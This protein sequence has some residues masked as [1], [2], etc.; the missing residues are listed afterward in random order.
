MGGGNLGA[1]AGNKRSSG[2]AA[3][4]NGTG[5]KQTYRVTVRAF[6]N[7]GNRSAAF[8]LGTFTVAR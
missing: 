8:S 3:V 5:K 4:A 7:S 6:D 1:D 2:Y